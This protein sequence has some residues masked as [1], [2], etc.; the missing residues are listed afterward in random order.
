MNYGMPYQ[1]SKNTIAPLIVEKL[2]PAENFVDLFFGGGAVTHAAMLSGKYRNFIAND[3]RN[4]PWAWNRCVSGDLKEY[5]R[6]VSRDEFLASDDPIVKMLWSFGSNMTTYAFSGD[7]QVIARMI[8]GADAMER[9]DAF[10]KTLSIFD[11]KGTPL[12]H[13]YHTVG[14][15]FNHMK[16]FYAVGGTGPVECSSKDYKDV[17]IPDN[18]VVYCDPPYE[19]TAGYGDC[20]DH[21]EF[22]EWARTREFPV[23]VSE[24]NAPDDFT[25]VFEYRKQGKFNG[26]SGA[27]KE[28]LFLHNRWK[29]G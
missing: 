22:W 3:L 29:D 26:D 16:R 8:M 9:K 4:T 6:F 2:P 24:M 17:D 13:D 20:F 27:R 7:N 11:R 5:E 23:Y 21:A 28:R 12:Y 15:H 19:G 1:G 18:S 10:L 25:A 14:S